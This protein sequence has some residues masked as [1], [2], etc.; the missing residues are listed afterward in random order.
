MNRTWQHFFG[1]GIVS[2]PDNFGYSGA[3][4]THPEL[5]DWLATEFVDLG[6]NF[7]KLHRLIVTSSVYRQSS[8]RPSGENQASK[9]SDST[10][11]GPDMV[12]SD[13]RLLWRMPLRRLESEIVRDSVLAVSGT[14]N[15]TQG[16]PPILLRAESDG[17]IAIDTERLTVPGDLY[18]RSI[19]L[20][21][22]RNYPLSELKVFDQPIAQ[23]NCTRRT[24]SALVLQALTMLNGEFLFD[25]AER[26]A[27]RIRRAGPKNRDAAIELAFRLALVRRPSAEETEL[28][29]KLLESQAQRY[30]TAR[31]MDEPAAAEAAM[32]DLC[33]MLL[34]TNEFLYVE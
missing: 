22:R 31:E 19:Y 4:P 24:S 13:N 15:R 33:Q 17:S 26:F 1:R 11:K 28:S 10:P 2:T 9:G 27:D 30:R 12:D 29:R 7:K 34:N 5:L 14:L 3:E 20:F 23:I 21:A 8:W 25:A 18:R 32:A 16:G 6:W